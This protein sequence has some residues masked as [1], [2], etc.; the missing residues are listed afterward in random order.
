MSKK[1]LFLL[2]IFIVVSITFVV[3]KLTYPQNTSSQYFSLFNATPTP[4][5]ESTLSLAP[6]PLQVFAGQAATAD[7]MLEVSGQPPSIVQFEIAYDPSTIT[8]VEVVPGDF[9]T[10]P[11]V[12]LNIVNLRTGRISYALEPNPEQTV[13]NQLG[14][15]AKINFIPLANRKSTSLTFLPKT[16]IRATGEQNTLKVGYGTSV[17]ISPLQTSYGSSSA[18]TVQ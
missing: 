18:N 2:T 8:N 4:V 1:F 14:A 11:T 13:F 3:I 16:T 9:F 7:V 10:N 17:I 5:S 12:L 15:V 6:N